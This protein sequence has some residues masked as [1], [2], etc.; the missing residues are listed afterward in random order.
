MQ[1]EIHLGPLTLQSFGL[2]MGL[3]F[4]VAGLLTA[5]RLKEIGRPPD[6]AYE[7]VF[8]ALIG[9][10]VGA[11]LWSI[12][13]NW[14]DAKNDLVGSIFS[15][16]GLVF[17]GGL[18]GGAIA[19]LGW[20]KW[21]G[22]LDAM[23]VDSV[24]PGLAAAYAIGRI[25]CQLAGD[26]DYGKPWDGPWAMAY[27]DGTVPTTETVHP[28]PVYET[29]AMGGVAWFLWHIRDRVRPGGLFALYLVLAG[30][31]RFLVEFLRRNDRVVAG[32]T[33]PQLVALG[34]MLGGGAWLLYL[35]SSSVPG[36]GALLSP[37]RGRVRHASAPIMAVTSPSVYPEAASVQDGRL[38]IGGCDAA[39]LARDFGTPAYVMAED[40]L[41]ARAR[42]FR[43]ALAAHHDGPGEVIFASKAC[44]VT[45]VLRVFAEEG[46]GCDVASGGELHLALKAGFEPARLY[47]HGNAKGEDELA[48]AIAAGVGTVVVDNLEDVA[49]LARVLPAGAR[50]AVLLRVRPG[51]DADT[52][53]AIL[54]GHAESKFGLDPREARALADDPPA[55]LDV[56]GFHFHLGSQLN[57]PTPYRAAVSVLAGLGRRAVYSLGGGYA[58]AYTADDRPPA[59]EEAV[60]AVVEAAHDL[61]GP[62]RELVLEPGRALVANAGVTLY[63]VE[64]VKRLPGGAR[65]VAVDGGMSDNPRPMLY[66]AVYEASVADRFG[67][68][69]EPATVVGK[70]CESGDVLIRRTRLPEVDPG[71]VLVT[72]VTG[73]YGHAMASNYNGVRRPPVVFCAGGEARAVVRRETYEDLGARDL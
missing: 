47:L 70:H 26:G 67:A 17:Y 52:H 49:K 37:P 32:L 33:V 31:E 73:A 35:R 51:I 46:L 19:V 7:M 42:A 60:A 3:G 4:V 58:V 66:D 9:G 44:P 28:T 69:G 56:R 36:A 29:L 55:H 61:L 5:K 27:P 62:G 65:L 63:T 25:G 14:D 30:A 38:L 59:I 8:A 41:R 23:L 22:T 12:V 40:D 57:D 64:S 1:P 10:I 71:D 21:R 43:G 24:A 15:G 11:R 34:M 2:M 53:A 48:A 18:L 72:P 45:A 20:A 54:T 16:T 13:E 68:P 39:G 50:Q 6:W